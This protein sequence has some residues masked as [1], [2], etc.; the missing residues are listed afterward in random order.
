MKG[1]FLLVFLLLGTGVVYAETLEETT[2]S[3]L[4]YITLSVEGENTKACSEID[5]P[6]DKP[7]DIELGKR[8]VVVSVNAEFLP[9]GSGETKVTAYA[10]ARK[11]GEAKHS[12]FIGGWARFN[13]PMEFISAGNTLTLCGETGQTTKK[14]LI[15][16]S[17]KI[18]TYYMPELKVTKTVLN[19]S[20]KLK[21]PFGVE[22][23]IENFG[24]EDVN[25]LVGYQ[26]EVAKNEAPE[27]SVLRG[28]TEFNGIIEKC[29]ERPENGNCGTPGLAKFSFSM[30]ANRIADITLLPA[31]LTYINIFGETAFVESS[32]PSLSVK[33][34][35]IIIRPIIIT[36]KETYKAGEQGQARLALNNEGVGGLTNV[37]YEIVSKGLEVKDGEG[38][39][40]RIEAGTTEYIGLMFG[41]GS[42]G[43]FTIGCNVSVKDSNF[44][45]QCDELSIAYEQP[46]LGPFVIFAVVLLI[47]AIG[48]YAYIQLK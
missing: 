40:A 30:Q 23:L 45:A 27:V 46:E 11:I 22:V 9:L 39:I 37:T 24:S 42:E 3:D 21:E 47:L 13:V 26:K 18:G 10:N 19:R 34:P 8:Y 29:A 25:V 20:P 2:L 43:E 15:K 44:S 17:S 31:Y 33:Q 12:D 36:E 14:I 5:F 4:G 28:S 6:Y 35:E 1:L 16:G 32:R 38:S 48:V 41:S 7:R